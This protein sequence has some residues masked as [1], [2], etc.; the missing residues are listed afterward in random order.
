MS[1]FPLVGGAIGGVGGLIYVGVGHL[2]WPVAAALFAIAGQIILTGA[3]HED[4][5]ADFAD[6]LGVRGDMVTKLAAMRDSHV[7]VFGAV[8]L[9]LSITL[10]AA[11]LASIPN[12]WAGL[13]ALIAAASLSRATIPF[14]MQFLPP[15]RPEGLAAQAGV[16]DFSTAALA[17][18]LA[19]VISLLCVGSG[20]TIAAIIG[21]CCGT[22]LVGFTAKRVLGG[23]TGD[24]LGAIQQVAEIFIL[25]GIASLW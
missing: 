22:A 9:I 14:A 12:V 18:V 5:L 25:L 2:Q 4:G 8:A 1:A 10:R 6:G 17:A 20:P 7:G 16:P 3:L 11:L 13:F 24:V 23:Y 21:A 15:A 19:M